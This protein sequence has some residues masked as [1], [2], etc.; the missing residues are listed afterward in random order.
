M[1]PLVYSEK[2]AAEKQTGWI[3][4]GHHISYTKNLTNNASPLLS[5]CVPYHMLEWQMVSWLPLHWVT[6]GG[7]VD[8]WM[9]G[10]GWADR[11]MTGGGWADRWMTG[12][13]WVDR[14]MTG[15]GWVESG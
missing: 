3:R 8:R 1:R 12:S 10:S 13:G 14:W 15:G 9:T 2:E 11:W 5:R 7:W 4:T 6:G